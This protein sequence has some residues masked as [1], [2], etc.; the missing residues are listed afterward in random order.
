MDKLIAFLMSICI[1]ISALIFG[2]MPALPSAPVPFTEPEPADTAYVYDKID[3]AGGACFYIGRPKEETLLTVHSRDF[4]MSEGKADNTAELN[5]AFAYCA[6]HKGTKLI[7]DRGVY[8]FTGN[9][10]IGVFGC[11]N[12][13]VEGNGSK[14]IFTSTASYNKLSFANSSFVEFRNLNVDWDWENDPIGSAVEIVGVDS[15]NHTMDLL[16]TEL[17]EVSE[18]IVIKAM[19]QCDEKT[20]TMGADRSSNEVYFYQI[21]YSVKSVEKLSSNVLRVTHSGVADHFEK[22]QVYKIGRAHV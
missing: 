1:T 18:S 16:F 12:L 13:L 7:I 17:S 21:P 9:D 15:K 22:G 10:T 8:R 4:G 20:F 19:T 6:A 2:A 14:F 11:E 3:G 5:E